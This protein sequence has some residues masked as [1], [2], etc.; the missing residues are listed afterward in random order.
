MGENVLMFLLALLFLAVGIVIGLFLFRKNLRR[1]P[2][3]RKR[4]KGFWKVPK[5]NTKRS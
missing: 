2:H 3:N 5:G 1:C 4:C